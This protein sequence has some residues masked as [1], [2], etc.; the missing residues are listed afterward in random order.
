M[1]FSFFVNRNTRKNKTALMIIESTSIF[2]NP[3]KWRY[4]HEMNKALI[5]APPSTVLFMILS[6][7]M[8]INKRHV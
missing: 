5:S 8:T 4:R 1:T 6:M 7:R 2:I 3:Y